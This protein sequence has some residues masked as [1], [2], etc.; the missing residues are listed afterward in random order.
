MFN[1][2]RNNGPR[3]AHAIACT[4]NNC[5]YWDQHRDFGTM[6]FPLMALENCPFAHINRQHGFVGGGGGRGRRGGARG[7]RA[8]GRG[9][10]AGAP[11]AGRAAGGRGGARRRRRGRGAGGP[12]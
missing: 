8:G 6:T 3:D 7:G 5:A 12:A 11:G 2:Q 4:T 1:K 9:G 10:G